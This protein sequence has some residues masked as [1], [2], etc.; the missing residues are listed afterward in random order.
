MTLSRQ[1]ASIFGDSAAEGDSSAPAKESFE[2]VP[3]TFPTSA[4]LAAT[5]KL[6]DLLG[7]SEFCSKEQAVEDARIQAASLLW[8]AKLLDAASSFAPRKSSE[9]KCK[10]GE[11]SCATDVEHAEPAKE[12]AKPSFK[13]TTGPVFD[14]LQAS[15]HT[16]AFQM[17]RHTAVGN[18]SQQVVDAVSQARKEI[19]DYLDRKGLSTQ[20]TTPFRKREYPVGTLDPRTVDTPLH[21][22]P[23]SLKFSAAPSH[24]TD[25]T[26]QLTHGQQRRSSLRRSESSTVATVVSLLEET[27]YSEISAWREHQRS[28]IEIADMLKNFGLLGLTYADVTLDSGKSDLCSLAAGL[29]P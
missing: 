25:L 12:P 7:A 27:Q 18:L 5:S 3:L 19:D 21:P 23:H 1:W 29:C 16:A 14:L 26:H 8:P 10:A 28:N 15:F 13:D 22:E 20:G 6:G 2:L 4:H 11:R 9:A 24:A 17:T